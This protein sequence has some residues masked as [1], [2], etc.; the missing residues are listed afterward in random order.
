MGEKHGPGQQAAGLVQGTTNRQGLHMRNIDDD[1]A[2]DSNN[3]RVKRKKK[4]RR[5]TR[6]K[7]VRQINQYSGNKRAGSRLETNKRAHGT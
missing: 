5:V 6:K 7:Q 3:R 1:L 4:I 2:Q